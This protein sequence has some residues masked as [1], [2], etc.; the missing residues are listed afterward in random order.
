M[1]WG[2]MVSLSFQTCS[3]S[4]LFRYL[5]Y[6]DLDFDIYRVHLDGSH[7]EEVFFEFEEI[8]GLAIDVFHNTLYWTFGNTIKHLNIT[9]WEEEGKDSFTELPVEKTIMSSEPQGIAV[10]NGTIYWSET[11]DGDASGG[12]IYTMHHGNDEP[13]LL[14]RNDSIR[15]Q[16]V[17]TFISETGR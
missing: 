6:I 8:K 16:D 9:K 5:Y 15:P 11:H 14:L 10:V 1:S 3:L 4:S 2:S 13:T 12:A 7:K 17:S